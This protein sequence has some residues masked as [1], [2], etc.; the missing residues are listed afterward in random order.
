VNNVAA[1]PSYGDNQWHAVWG[2]ILNNVSQS[3]GVFQPDWAGWA[4]G[5]SL[6]GSV[7]RIEELQAGQIDHVMGLGVGEPLGKDIIPAS[8]CPTANAPVSSTGAGISWPADDSDGLDSNTNSCAIPEGLRFRLPASLNLNNY[9]LTPVG[10]VVAE[11]AQK[12][13]FVV[14]DTSNVNVG[15][16]FGDPTTYTVAGLANPYTSGPGVGGVGSGGLFAGVAPNLILQN[17]PWD[18]LQALPFN[19]G[20]PS[21]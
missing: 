8:S 21:Q 4:S 11:A 20:E 16:H 10:R 14:D 18:Q 12:Y 13:G 15:P 17:F 7:I 9:D 19:Y 2:G 6:L 3:D 5:L 1:V